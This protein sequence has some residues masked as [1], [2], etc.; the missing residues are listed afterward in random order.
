VIRHA[1]LAAAVALIAAT[2]IP[3]AAAAGFDYVFTCN[4]ASL[5]ADFAQ[6]DTLPHSQ[7]PPSQWYEQRDGRYLS[8]GWGPG[9]VALPP[10][11]VPPDAGCDATAWKQERI[12][13]AALHY[14]N[15][16]GNPQGLQYR[17]RGWRPIAG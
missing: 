16:A 15:D 7:T 9:A 11:A 17:H 14:V 12:L 6:R 1:T 4:Q 2:T 3:T 8:G 10:V 5:T 13:S